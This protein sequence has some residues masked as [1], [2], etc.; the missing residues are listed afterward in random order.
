M[1][2][3]EERAKKYASR[4]WSALNEEFNEDQTT[5]ENIVED[6]FIAGAES[7]REELLRWRDPDKELPEE[8]TPVLVRYGHIETRKAVV[9]LM[10]TPGG[11]RV[12][13]VDNSDM[14]ILDKDI[15]GWRPIIEL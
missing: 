7:E 9:W 6:A 14:V 11:R 13:N 8:Y 10:V 15:I 12:W 1:K 5:F 3:I 2:S 4:A